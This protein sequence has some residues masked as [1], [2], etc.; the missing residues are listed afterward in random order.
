MLNS[1]LYLTIETFK[2]SYLISFLNLNFILKILPK[3]NYRLEFEANVS[4]EILARHSL[5]HELF[6][7]L[8]Q[9]PPATRFLKLCCH[10]LK[11]LKL[12]TCP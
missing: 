3:D 11:Y 1:K 2:G 10:S 5:P 6:Y 8:C 12:K 7:H 9:Q 4:L